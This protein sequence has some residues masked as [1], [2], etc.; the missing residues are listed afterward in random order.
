MELMYLFLLLIP[1][2]TFSSAFYNPIVDHGQDPSVKYYNDNYYLVQSVS[3]AI[4][5]VMKSSRL[6]NLGNPDTNVTV[7]VGSGDLCCQVWA[8][9]LVFIE[10]T[11]HWY[12]YF[13]ADDGNFVAHHSYV[14]ESVGID[15]LGPYNFIGKMAVATDAFAI[16]STVLKLDNQ[17]YYIWSG[18]P[19]NDSV[20]QQN[21]YIASLSG[22]TNITSDR[23]LIS[24]PIYPWEFDSNGFG[25]NEGPAVLQWDGKTYITYSASTTGQDTYCFG[26]LTYIG[27]DP[28]QQS[29]WLK[30]NTSVFF[31]N[32]AESV[33]G[34]GHNC[35]T[36]SP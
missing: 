20:P 23:F 35:F 25:N 4:I 19:V 27:G 14:L 18:S 30:S 16:D 1:L 22:P 21:I 15:P 7:W 32:P 10:D 29:S 6:E 28:L 8:P 24:E 11:N 17:L 33:Y 2:V 5:V 34:P 12:I 36:T 3:E 13:A 9:E 26:M 31:Q